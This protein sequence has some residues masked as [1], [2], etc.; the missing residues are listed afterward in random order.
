MPMKKGKRIVRRPLSNKVSSKFWSSSWKYFL[1]VAV[2]IVLFLVIFLP[3]YFLVIRKDSTSNSSGG[4]GGGG[5][6]IPRPK[7]P[8]FNFIAIVPEWGGWATT[9]KDSEP[10]TW[11]GAG[12]VSFDL[13][14]IANHGNG[15]KIGKI[16]VSKS[17]EEIDVYGS[18]GTAIPWPI[19]ASIFGWKTRLEMIKTVVDSCAGRNDVPCCI[20]VQ[21]INKYPSEIAPSNSTNKNFD[22]VNNLCS[23]NCSDINDKNIVATYN[24]GTKFPAYLLVPFQGC[25]GDCSIAYP[26]CYNRCPDIQKYVANFNYYT[27]CKNSDG[28]SIIPPNGCKEIKWMSDNDWKMNSSIEQQYYNNNDATFAISDQTEMGENINTAKSSSKN[29]NHIN[30]CS[31]KNMHFDVQRFLPSS[32]SSTNPFW[33]DL[34]V[35]NMADPNNSISLPS[36]FIYNGKPFRGGDVSNTIV[37]YML[38]K[39]NIFGNFDILATVDATGATYPQL[40]STLPPPSCGGSGSVSY[41]GISYDDPNLCKNPVCVDNTPSNCPAGYGF[42]NCFSNDSCPTKKVSIKF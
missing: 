3:I 29:P 13:Q 2:I 24:N 34:L 22:M 41:C 18:M 10:Q 1:V 4:D 38:V 7:L 15:N 17:G 26:D 6:I 21:L 42:V 40:P 28:T 20:I 12:T 16:K 37:R 23:S 35:N 30:Y 11:P 39:G 27:E 14:K 19:F 33:C 8:V 32:S 5:S 31:G 9:T 25:G 36:P